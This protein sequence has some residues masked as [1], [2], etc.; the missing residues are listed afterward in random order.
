MCTYYTT[1]FEFIYENLDVVLFF[2]CFVLAVR[3]WSSTELQKKTIEEDA[4]TEKARIYATSKND[5]K[6]MDSLVDLKLS[7]VEDAG[8]EDDEAGQLM[9]L[10]GMFGDKKDDVAP[11]DTA[12][13]T[14][15]QAFAQTPA[16]ADA[17]VKFN[18]FQNNK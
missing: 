10:M 8:F 17:M 12:M 11:A 16:G 5:Q 7:D 9:K 15:L 14:E 13:L 1:M 4:K 6:R 2:L 3:V 18:S